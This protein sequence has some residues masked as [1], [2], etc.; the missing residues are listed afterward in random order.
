M[1][2]RTLIS[3]S[4]ALCAAVASIGVVYAEP[5]NVKF[6]EDYKTLELY[7]TVTRGNVF[8]NAYTTREALDA[9]QQ[10]EEVPDGT[11]VVLEIF[12][13]EEFW[14]LFVMEKGEGWGE[15]YD[16]ASRTGDWQLQWYWPDGTINTD[17]NTA[18]C[19][20]CHMSRE[21]RSFMF[22]YNDARRAE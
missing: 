4:L 18:R 7:T 20:A 19:R 2:R 8:E 1:N 10:G 5:N 13:D 21:D 11:Q 6:P 9:I 15:E 16:E 17:E 12:R 3:A 14:R 22:T